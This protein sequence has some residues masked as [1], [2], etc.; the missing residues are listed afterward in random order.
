MSRESQGNS[1]VCE[2]RL[3]EDFPIPYS[4]SAKFC[5]H[6]PLPNTKL[7]VYLVLCQ[8]QSQILNPLAWLHYTTS[9]SIP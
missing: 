8:F 6:F 9:F 1:V 7:G 5:R 3:S 4:L 2:I